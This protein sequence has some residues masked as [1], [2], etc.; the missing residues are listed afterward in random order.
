MSGPLLKKSLGQHHLKDPSSCRPLVEFLAPHGR[1]VVE[2][3]PGGG[4]LTRALLDA[5]AR[6]L[7]W[8]LDRD[9]TFELA[10]RLAERHGLSVVQG[11]ALKLPWGRLP[12][13]TQVA[14]NLPYNVATAIL[15]RMLDHGD[16]IPRAAVLVQ[17]E[18]ARRLVAE[19]GS[20]SYGALS[21]LVAARC[22][23]RLLA[24][25]RPGSFRPP[26]KVDSA[27]VGFSLDPSP[28]P[29]EIVALRELVFAAFA[30]RRKTLRNALAARWPV[31]RVA[32]AL[33]AAGLDP[34]V[35]AEELDLTA[36]YEL[37]SEL[38]TL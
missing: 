21:V 18:V 11:D 19:P 30:H 14:G 20:K 13:G 35:R 31:E 12:R 32:A 2:V 36:F 29:S 27:F 3:G 24:R 23:A 38:R 28:D 16:R 4:V 6:V 7:A 5:G 8:E 33:D 15:D 9:W 10:R 22:S 1:R 37:L 34:S 26:P 25:V 17:L